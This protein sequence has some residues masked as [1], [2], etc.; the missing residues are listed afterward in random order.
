MITGCDLESLPSAQVLDGVVK[1]LYTL[2]SD[3]KGGTISAAKM[4]VACKLFDDRIPVEGLDETLKVVDGVGGLTERKLYHWLVLMF[5]DCSVD[6]FLKG[7]D[8]IG[9]AAKTLHGLS[10]GV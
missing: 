9:E 2:L 10:F 4:I 8:E 6:E 7:V 1:W 3:D 5:G